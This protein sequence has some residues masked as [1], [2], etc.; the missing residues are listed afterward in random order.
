MKTRLLLTTLL[1]TTGLGL[2][3]AAQAIEVSFEKDDSLP[4]VYLNVAIKAGAV[5]D[6]QGQ[7]GI[8]NFMGE[9]L[10][11][12]TKTRTKEQID[13]EL[14]QMGATLDVEVRSEALILRG[15]VLS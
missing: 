10:L 2:F 8:T 7:S 12:G 5:A 3:S 4:L 14:D 1:L 13:L 6:A 15:S 9:M 11:R